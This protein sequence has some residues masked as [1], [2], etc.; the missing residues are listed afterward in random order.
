MDHTS[1]PQSLFQN[2]DTEN[3]N[4]IILPPEYSQNSSSGHHSSDYQNQD[5]PED[6]ADIDINDFRKLQISN[7]GEPL[8][9][10]TYSIN[11]NL[12][13]SSGYYGT[14]EISNFDYNFLHVQKYP[15]HDPCTETNDY[16]HLSAPQQN[17]SS[18]PLGFNR[19]N[20]PNGGTDN[21]SSLLSGTDALVSLMFHEEV[22]E[23]IFHR[24]VQK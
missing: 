22:D 20:N 5:I 1:Q 19:Q 10:D 18:R 17:F 13:A 2:W 7:E 23:S 14:G 8:Y 3:S 16:M 11:E 6:L 21:E 15:S 9:S 4:N 12:F 24:L